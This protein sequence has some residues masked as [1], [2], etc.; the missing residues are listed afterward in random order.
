M[1]ALH[2]FHSVVSKN[3]V[4]GFK[5]LACGESKMMINDSYVTPLRD[6]VDSPTAI[7]KTRNGE[8]GNGN[9]ER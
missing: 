8:S 7:F 1:A 6:C 3:L 4:T 5:N 9:G 2:G